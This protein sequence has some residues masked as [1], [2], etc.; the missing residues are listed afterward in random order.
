MMFGRGGTPEDRKVIADKVKQMAKMG[1]GGY[2]RIV[3]NGFRY[4]FRFQEKPISQQAWTE[5]LQ[6]AGFVDIE[7]ERIV[8][9]AGIIK[10]RRP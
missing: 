4:M 10:A 8:A 2:W 9:E 7:V 1:F 3:K 6:E 5:L